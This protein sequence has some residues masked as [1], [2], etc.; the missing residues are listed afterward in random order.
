M[1]DQS[2]DDHQ[3][4]S[5]TEPAADSDL[6]G[7]CSDCCVDG[8][9]LSADCNVAS[10]CNVGDN[11]THEV[12]DKCDDVCRNHT[13]ADSADADP[14]HVGLDNVQPH[15]DASHCTAACSQSSGNDGLDVTA[16]E[17]VISEEKVKQI[18]EG[19]QQDVDEPIIDA[20]DVYAGLRLADSWN[21]LTAERSREFGIGR[22]A[23]GRFS[24][25]AGGS[26]SLVRRLQ[27]YSKLDGH[28]G[29]VNA[30]HFNDAGNSLSYCSV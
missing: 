23:P 29:C 4:S 2:A 6:V 8:S 1:M 21:P 28:T 22:V 19:N 26:L 3:N 27:L 25:K 14:L 7:V 10:G 20:I 18:D 9:L 13:D 17:N 12:D 24:C 11:C 16:A 5:L 15:P 30:L